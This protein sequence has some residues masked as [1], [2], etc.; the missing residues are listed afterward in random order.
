MGYQIGTT[1]GGMTDLQS[2]TTPV[3]PPKTTFKPY[4]QYLP[5]GSGAVRGGGWATAEWRY[6]A[7]GDDY[8]TRAQRDQL[9]AFCTGASAEVY[10]STPVNDTADQ[11]KT[12]RA[13]MIWPE[14]EVKDFTVRR[15]FVIRFQRLV[16]VTP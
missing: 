4:S 9:K 5:L 2:L 12:F 8:L 10:I 7:S 14:E 15:D 11:F 1:L 13:I 16:E 6:N 3:D